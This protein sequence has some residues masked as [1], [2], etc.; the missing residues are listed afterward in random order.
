M[1]TAR[2]SS[3]STRHLSTK[4]GALLSFV[5][6][7]CKKNPKKPPKK[8]SKKHRFQPKRTESC[9]G[10]TSSITRT[11]KRRGSTFHPVLLWSCIFQKRPQ[12]GSRD[13]QGFFFICRIYKLNHYIQAAWASAQNK[14]A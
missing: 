2:S 13:M 11:R 14:H 8:T 1:T 5:F 4:T 12:L 6:L 3:G 10:G 7:A 9:C